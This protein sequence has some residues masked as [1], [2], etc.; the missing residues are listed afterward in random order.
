MNPPIVRRIR[1]P[2]CLA[3]RPAE[4]GLRR[5]YTRLVLLAQGAWLALN[6][7]AVT[8]RAINDRSHWGEAGQRP[9]AHHTGL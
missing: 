2:A 3:S 4:D 5:R 8:S 6:N 1:D 9:L 7:K